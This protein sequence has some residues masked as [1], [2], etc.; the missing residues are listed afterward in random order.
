MTDRGHE[1][2]FAFSRYVPTE[3]AG[4]RKVDPKTSRPAR[5]SPRCGSTY[6]AESGGCGSAAAQGTPQ[7][8]TIS[9][10]DA[11]L[12]AACVLGV[13][14]RRALTR[15]DRH[16]VNVLLSIG[17]PAKAVAADVDRHPGL[18]RKLRRQSREKA[19]PRLRLRAANIQGEGVSQ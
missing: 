10:A 5:H 15:S 19:V 12:F 11:E 1:S 9:R 14:L 16:R 13:R 3:A 8:P 17:E 6:S 2:E 7:S 4:R 18:V